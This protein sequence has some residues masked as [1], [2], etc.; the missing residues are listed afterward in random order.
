MARS[1]PRK[2]IKRAK[3]PV[4]NLPLELLS[5][6]SAYLMEQFDTGTFSLGI[7]QNQA[8][9][10]VHDLHII[11]A[12]TERILTTPLPIAYQVAISQITWVYLLTL[13]FQLT[14]LTGWLCIPVTVTT[15][16]IALSILYIGNEIENPFGPD[17]NDLP[18]ESYCEQIVSDIN[19]IAAISPVR[20][21]A[22][23]HSPHSKPLYPLSLGSREFWCS[24]ATDDIRNALRTRADPQ[25]TTMW[26]R[27]NSWKMPMVD[28]D[29]RNQDSVAESD[30]V[31]GDCEKGECQKGDSRADSEAEQ[32]KERCCPWEEGKGRRHISFGGDSPQRKHSSTCTRGKSAACSRLKTGL[33]EGSQIGGFCV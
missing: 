32:A 27:L 24:R 16:Y 33:T 25:R 29:H 30:T 14:N 7:A 11:L 18:L 20:M 9:N 31:F 26:E 28:S 3:R 23:I 19:V 2:Q 12:T 10:N 15:A 22:E 6:L 1:N 21:K 5:H 17:V 13:P 4:G 8:L